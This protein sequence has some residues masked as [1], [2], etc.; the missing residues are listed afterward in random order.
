[1]T[2][3]GP[4]SRAS[5][6]GLLL[7]AAVDFA[8]P[9]AAAA[10]AAVTEVPVRTGVHDGYS[11]LVFDW[12]APVAYRLEQAP[13]RAVLYFSRPARLDLSRFRADPG[14]L[15]PALTM[16][17]VAEGSAVELSLPPGVSLR[18]FMSDSKVVVD[19]LAP[20]RV[21]SRDLDA[22]AADAILAAEPENVD[23]IV[24]LAGV[25]L[26]EGNSDACRKNIRGS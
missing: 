26:R 10:G 24:L 11:R 15:I 12:D 2:R 22:I 7:A 8:S 17:P 5:I 9:A 13:G 23:A 21:A 4:W 6:Y 1:M 20:R 25:N 19:V 18:H 16:K 14:R 3:G